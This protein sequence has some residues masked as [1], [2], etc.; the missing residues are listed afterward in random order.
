MIRGR[1][2][3]PCNIHEDSL[4]YMLITNLYLKISCGF[5]SALCLGVLIH[6]PANAQSCLAE[7]NKKTAAYAEWQN[8]LSN[9]E[10]VRSCKAWSRMVK[11]NEGVFSTSMTLR[12]C[13]ASYGVASIDDPTYTEYLNKLRAGIVSGRKELARMGCN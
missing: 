11:A 6:S 13:H 3:P 4:E 8:A 5:A 7:F 10:A 12:Y 2:N 9:L 1:G